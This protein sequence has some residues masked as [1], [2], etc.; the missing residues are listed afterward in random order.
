MLSRA[1]R[2]AAADQRRQARKAAVAGDVTGD[3]VIDDAASGWLL[4]TTIVLG[5]LTAA[6]LALGCYQ[7]VSHSARSIPLLLVAA[8]FLAATVRSGAKLAV[9][10]RRRRHQLS[11]HPR[12]G[13]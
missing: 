9:L 8:L 7:A 6:L 2:H 12:G 10:R 1:Y 11:G 4:A 3:K 5:L 13:A